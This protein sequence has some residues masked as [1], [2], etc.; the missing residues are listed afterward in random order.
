MSSLVYWRVKER[1]Q[2]G[3]CNRGIS[4]NKKRLL[5]IVLQSIVG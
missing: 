1:F 5:D 4:P 2:M 3:L